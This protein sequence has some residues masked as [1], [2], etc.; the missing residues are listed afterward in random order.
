MSKY[1]TVIF[2]SQ[3][4]TNPRSIGAVLPS[5]KF[6]ADKMVESIDFKKAKYIV[7]Y[8]PGTG[9][10]TNKLLENEIWILLF[11]WWKIIKNFIYY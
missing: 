7:E 5:S 10:F 1:E 9:V 8:G 4:I 2:L 11:Y 6:L 3:Y